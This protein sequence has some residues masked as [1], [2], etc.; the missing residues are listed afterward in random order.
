MF[1]KYQI[2]IDN[3]TGNWKYK[4]EPHRNVWTDNNQKIKNEIHPS[5]DMLN[6]RLETIKKKTVNWKKGK[7]Y[8]E[9]TTEK[10]MET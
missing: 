7:N 4:T 6:R 10:Q 5:T 2:D 3:W 1:E 9:W 8:P